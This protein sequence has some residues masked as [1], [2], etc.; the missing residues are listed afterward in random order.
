MKH[1]ITLNMC[2]WTAV[3]ELGHQ[4]LGT[5]NVFLKPFGTSDNSS[6]KLKVS[7]NTPASWPILQNLLCS[8]RFIIRTGCF[9]WIHCLE[10]CSDAKLRDLDHRVVR[11]YGGLCNHSPPQT[12]HKRHW[13]H[14]E[15]MYH[16]HLCYPVCLV[17][18]AIPAT[19][20]ERPSVTGLAIILSISFLSSIQHLIL[21]IRRS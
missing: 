2:Y 8:A 12:V 1:L 6:E 21:F 18:G 7:S 11:G 10:R 13:T 14:P 4:T 19:A 5:I 20:V 16:C 3:I 17:G 9:A 15:S